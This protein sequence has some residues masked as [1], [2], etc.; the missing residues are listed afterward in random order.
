MIATAGLIRGQEKVLIV[1]IEP[2]DIA[3]LM[4]G[5]VALLK[6]N[7]HILVLMAADLDQMKE[8]LRA[9]GFINDATMI[10]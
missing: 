6:T 1:S 7:P 4:A 2:E 8:R 9:S 10:F 5:D 3:D